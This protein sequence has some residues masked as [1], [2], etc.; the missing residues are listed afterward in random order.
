MTVFKAFLK[1]LNKNKGTIILYTV[2]LFSISIF[3]MQ[4]NESSINF[5]SSKPDIYVIDNDKSVISTDFVNY[6]KEN[7]NFVE[8]KENEDSLMDAIFYRDVNYIITIPENYFEDLLNNNDAVLDIRTT[9]DYLA[10]LAEMISSR[11]IKLVEY[12]KRSNT[13]FEDIVLNVRKT[14]ENSV[15]VSLTSRLDTNSLS[16]MSTY[17][18][19]SNYTILASLVFVLCIILNSFKNEN[20]AKRIV[21]SGMNYKK[22]NRYLLLSSICFSFVLFLIYVLFSFIIIGNNMISINGIICIINMLIFIICSTAFAFLLSSFINN[23]DALGGIV[24]TIALGSSFLCGAFV[25]Q[26][27]LPDSVLFLGHIFPSYYFIKS[28]ELAIEIENLGNSNFYSII[29]NNCILICFT[30]VFILLKKYIDKRNRV[31]H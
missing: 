5:V 21:V 24:N 3:N 18:N 14:L 29:I 31:F 6:L 25:P 9:N 12:F 2:I 17:F 8:I 30:I 20:V 22:F 16:K 19:F 26:R 15:D 28:N 13:S 1:I 27:W 10:K 11:Y 4:N 23:K 7:S